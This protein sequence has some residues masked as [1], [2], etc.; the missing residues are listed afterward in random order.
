VV[1]GRLPVLL[2]ASRDGVVMMDPDSYVARIRNQPKQS[3]AR[4]YLAWKRGYRLT[5]PERPDS[6]S[7][8]G[9]QAVRLQLD[10]M[11]R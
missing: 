5:E 3:Y 2:L 6:L 10:P 11:F 9:A 8:M 4:E 1:R 7:Y